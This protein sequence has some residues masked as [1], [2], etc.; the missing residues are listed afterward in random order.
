MHLDPD[1][2]SI[3][4]ISQ[5]P[6][7]IF[8][9]AAAIAGYAPRWEQEITALMQHRQRFVVVYDQL[10]TEESQADRK[11]RGIW[12]KHNKA[13]L[14]SVCLALIS[15]EPDAARREQIQ[16]MGAMAVKAFGVAHVAVAS[17]AEAQERTQGLLS[18]AG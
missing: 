13:A 1:N 8:N 6:L 5:F 3:H 7:V 11:H 4:D 12:L 2:F 10:R 16:A 14:A 18:A 17:L 15:V 9:P